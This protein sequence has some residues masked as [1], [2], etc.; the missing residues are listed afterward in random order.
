VGDYTDCD[1]YKQLVEKYNGEKQKALDG[2]QKIGQE[3][4]AINEK[5]K[6]IKSEGFLK[7][8]KRSS[9]LKELEAK[10]ENL[11]QEKQFLIRSYLSFLNLYLPHCV[12]CPCQYCPYESLVKLDYGIWSRS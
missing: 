1:S 12:H 8:M 5:I 9:E 7:R 6:E 2:N 10:R 3:L 11:K 4:E